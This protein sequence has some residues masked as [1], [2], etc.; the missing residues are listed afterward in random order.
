[1][2]AFFLR[3]K[4]G[5]AVSRIARVLENTAID[6]K[7][8]FESPKESGEKIGYLIN[9]HTVCELTPSNMIMFDMTIF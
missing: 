3:S 1:M 7:Y 4:E 2:W 6:V 5:V 9:M 8:G